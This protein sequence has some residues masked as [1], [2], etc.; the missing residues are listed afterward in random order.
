MKLRELKETAHQQFVRGKFSQCAQTYQQVLRLAPRDPNM[1]VR[2]AEACRR[3]GDRQQAVASYRTAAELLLE[4]GCETRA[5]G[6]LKAALELDPRDP[7]LR[8]VVARLGTQHEEPYSPDVTESRDALPMLPALESGLDPIPPA[9]PGERTQGAV[10]PEEPSRA[11][12]LPPIHR[13]L[14]AAPAVPPAVPPVLLPAPVRSQTPLPRLAAA[15]LP[16]RS[17]TAGTRAQA[18]RPAVPPVLTPLPVTTAIKATASV[19]PA[20]GSFGPPAGARGAV[21]PPPPPAEALI[22]AV[23]GMPRAQLNAM[24]TAQKPL[25]GSSPRLEV[26]RLSPSAVA[27]RSSPHD[28]WA[29]IRSHTPLELHVVEDLEKLPPMMQDLSA[30]LTVASD[31]EAPSSTVH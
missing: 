28:G 20:S 17:A 25:S 18:A 27:F 3:A 19:A 21:V 2:L 24:P 6:A 4:L 16:P 10:G 22:D 7:F 31:A 5:R 11:A 30:E 1:H 14:P 29:V 8:E 12:P 26:R 23:C 15:P 9:L 13:V